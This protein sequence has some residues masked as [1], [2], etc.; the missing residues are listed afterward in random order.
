MPEKWGIGLGIMK[1]LEVWFFML[2]CLWLLDVGGDEREVVAEPAVGIVAPFSG[3]MGNPS[4]FWFLNVETSGTRWKRHLFVIILPLYLT[5]FSFLS[6]VVPDCPFVLHFF[7]LWIHEL[8]SVGLAWRIMAI[9]L[10][11]FKVSYCW[12]SVWCLHAWCSA[13]G[14]AW[15]V[16]VTVL[17]SELA[18]FSHLRIVRNSNHEIQRH[19]N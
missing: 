8:D 16:Y 9:I 11:P 15:F 3:E 2:V 5:W 18:M 14:T 13:A 17:A 6:L 1:T 19:K 10:P 7:P 12:G 4:V